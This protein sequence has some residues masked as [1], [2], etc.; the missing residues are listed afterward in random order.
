MQILTKSHRLRV[1]FM[2]GISV[3]V[4]AGIEW[5]LYVVQISRHVQYAG[6]A[7]RQQHKTIIL[8]PRRGDILDRDGQVLATST[9]FDTVYFVPARLEGRSPKPELAPRL[10]RLLERDEATIVHMLGRTRR[11]RVERKL[12]PDKVA[13]LHLLEDELNLPAGIFEYEKTGKRL[14]PQG[15]LAGPVLGIT[16]IDETGDNR[17][18]EGVELK[19]N[20]RLRGSQTRQKV[21]TNVWHQGIGPMDEDLLSATFGEKIVLTIDSELQHYAE[22]A[23]RQGIGNVQAESGVAIVMDVASGDLLAVANCP[24]FDPNDFSRSRAFQRRNRSLTDPIEIGSVMKVLTATI[25]IDNHLVRLDEAINCENG[26][27][28]IEG[29]RVRDSHPMGLVSFPETFVHSSNIAFAKLGPRIEP[30]LYYRSLRGFGLGQR[31]GV[32]LSG[33]SRGVL[34]PITEWTSLSRTSLPM[35][36]EASM[37]AVQVVAAVA[38]VANEGIRMKPRLVSEVLSHDGRRAREFPNEEVGR[39]ASAATCRTVLDLMEKAVTEGT[40]KRAVLPGYR[41]AGKTGTTRKLVEGR[42]YTASFA[43]VLPAGDPKVAIFVYVDEPDPQ[44][45]RYGGD[46][47]APIFAEVA[48]HAARILMIEP[49]YPEE[50]RDEHAV[51]PGRFASASGANDGVWLEKVE[52]VDSAESADGDTSARAF[53]KSSIA[54]SS[55]PKPTGGRLGTMPSLI[56]LPMT[57]A[58]QRAAT[59]GIEI[60]ILGTGLAVDQSFRPGSKLAPGEVVEVIFAGRTARRDPA[61][62][63]EGEAFASSGASRGA[64]AGVSALPDL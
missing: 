43:G 59:A 62:R 49:D 60:R 34:R 10:A 37:T 15:D 56:G 21:V 38:A 46:V 25:L 22:K 3:L 30:D 29:R 52:S 33:E 26:V 23:L 27:A 54:Q 44:M 42:H 12:E 51:R 36:Y 50:L 31:S 7:R 35:G 17:G 41:I 16:G 2:A 9:F 63:A 55:D 47:S 6:L 4:F 39:V 40:G 64:L 14:Y 11:T 8:N 24:D 1:L 19:F 61:M 20:E 57:A 45:G 13:A 32:G 58:I 53:A 48:A 5:R 28:M 18:L